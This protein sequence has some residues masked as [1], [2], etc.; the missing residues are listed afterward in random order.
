MLSR[1]VFV[2]DSICSVFR[3]KVSS[4]ELCERPVRDRVRTNPR[5]TSCYWLVWKV[6]HMMKRTVKLG[7]RM[8]DSLL[9]LV[10]SRRGCR[11]AL[12]S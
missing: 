5:L 3:S 10:V 1:D 2:S 12:S 6:V 11:I 8:D 4:S 7:S 9:L